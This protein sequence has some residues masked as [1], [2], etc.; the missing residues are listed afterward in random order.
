MAEWVTVAIFTALAGL[1]IPVGAWLGCVEHIRP[2]WL[3][4]E[5]RHTVMAFGGGA[6]LSAVALVL[7]PEGID[8]LPIW[9]VVLS[10][11]AGGLSFMLFDMAL[12]SRGT[13]ASQFIAMLADFIPE[14]VALGA[15]FAASTSTG[16]L[17]ALLIG[18]QNLP[19]GFNAYREIRARERVPPAVLLRR[20]TAVALLGPA[21]GLA[22]YFWLT[23]YPKL[24]GVLMLFAAAGILYLT[25]QDIAPQVALKRRWFPPMGAVMGFLLGVIGEM[26]L[27]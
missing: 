10:F 9:A 6:L 1:A 19:E 11:A 21:A 5:V 22:G 13:S 16:P 2:H 25:F 26:L 15:G 24:V 8:R 18:L 17:L 12:A 7:V 4:N 3:E 23:P 14:S 27:Q 20:F